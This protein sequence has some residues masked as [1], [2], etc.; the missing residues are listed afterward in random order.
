MMSS[1]VFVIVKEWGEYSDKGS[2]CICVCDSQDDAMKVV[3]ILDELEEFC[4]QESIILKS[5]FDEFR[6][7][8]TD[9]NY[10]NPPDKFKLD[11]KHKLNKQQF[12]EKYLN[13]YNQECNMIRENNSE[14]QKKLAKFI[15]ES[16][17]EIP[18]K[19]HDF[20][21]EIAISPYYASR[22]KNWY[23]IEEVILVKP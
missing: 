18:N 7:T 5:T 17:P 8:L 20:K 2:R 23:N 1:K 22:D 14:N 11:P 15:E 21:D 9:L 10:P 13:S 16:M 4:K 19:F 12:A 6:E 3:S